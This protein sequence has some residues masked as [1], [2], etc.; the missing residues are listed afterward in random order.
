MTAAKTYMCPYCGKN[1]L[2]TTKTAPFIR[3]FLIA[4][5]LGYKTLLG[6]RSCVRKEIF[7]E[8]G[9]SSLVGWF[10]ITALLI[11]PFLLLYNIIQGIFVFP[12]PDKV[13][14]KL[15][16]AGLAPQ[17]KKVDLTQTGYTLATA[18]IAVDGKIEPEEVQA[19]K[20]IGQKIL[21]DFDPQAF[22]KVVDNYQ[23]LP[24]VDTLA[25][26]LKDALTSEGKQ[27]MYKYLLAIAAADGNIATE[28]KALLTQVAQGM[29]MQV[30]TAVT[31]S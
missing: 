19:A 22:Q 9:L 15:Q 30:K 17:R 21:T 31:A 12:N 23:N 16:E 20:Q 5:R 2:E 6:C 18:M 1:E 4:Y 3:G 11:N 10:S 24:A 25:I 7:K 27:V 13:N 14:K 8:V 26:L 29:G 28:E